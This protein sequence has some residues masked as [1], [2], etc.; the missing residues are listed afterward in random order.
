MTKRE[1]NGGRTMPRVIEKPFGQSN[2]TIHFVVD[3][4]LW[5]DKKHPPWNLCLEASS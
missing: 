3:V 2:S 1:D 5:I 4:V